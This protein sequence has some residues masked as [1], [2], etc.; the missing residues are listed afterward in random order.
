M[1]NSEKAYATGINLQTL[2]LLCQV[3]KIKV[4]KDKMVAAQKLKSLFLST[5][6]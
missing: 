6:A 1:V 4:F 5:R 2:I 3:R